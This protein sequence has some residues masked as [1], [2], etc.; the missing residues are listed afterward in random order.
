MKVMAL[1]ATNGRPIWDTVYSLGSF[2]ICC[3]PVNRGARRRRTAWC[4]C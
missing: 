2:Q 4:T 1:D 3:G